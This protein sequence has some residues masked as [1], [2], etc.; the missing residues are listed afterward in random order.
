MNNEDRNENEISTGEDWELF[1]S[2]INRRRRDKTYY[3][4]RDRPAERRRNIR[5]G[6]ALLIAGLSIY[7]YMNRPWAMGFSP[8]KEARKNFIQKIRN[9]IAEGNCPSMITAAEYSRHCIKGSTIGEVVGDAHKDLT[10]EELRKLKQSN[11]SDKKNKGGVNKVTKR[12][13]ER[14]DKSDL[15]KVVCKPL[16]DYIGS[17]VKRIIIDLDLLESN[18]KSGD[19]KDE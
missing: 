9:C 19:K 11:N 4:I 14:V 5:I 16:A 13:Q 10:L 18:D 17:R 2:D 12:N 1:G 3:I 15:S 6:I 8:G 7:G